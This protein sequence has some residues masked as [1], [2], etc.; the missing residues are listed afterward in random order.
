MTTAGNYTIVGASPPTVTAVAFTT[1]K[2]YIRL[3][4]SGVLN[5]N[6]AYSLRVADNTFGDGVPSIYNIATATPIFI[7]RTPTQSGIAETIDV[8]TPTMSTT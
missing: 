5:L 4:L 3:T 8:G 7:D 6:N 1:G 2:S